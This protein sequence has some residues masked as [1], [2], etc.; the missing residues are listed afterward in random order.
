MAIPRRWSISDHPNARTGPVQIRIREELV[1][2]NDWSCGTFF[3]SSPCHLALFFYS[4][5]MGHFVIPSQEA[6][7]W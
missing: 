6:R 3:H 1:R 5:V 7:T 2:V 4:N